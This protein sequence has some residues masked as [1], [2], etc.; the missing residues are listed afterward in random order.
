MS[1]ATPP[2]MSVPPVPVPFFRKPVGVPRLVRFESENAE[3][4]ANLRGSA[5]WPP[6]RTWIDDRSVASKHE[7]VSLK[8]TRRCR[9]YV[10]RTGVC[11]RSE[12]SDER[13][14]AREYTFRSVD[15]ILADSLPRVAPWRL[16]ARGAQKPPP[17]SVSPA[18]PKLPTKSV[19]AT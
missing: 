7:P 6:A 11:K 2:R 8:W 3:G 1:A 14:A 12:G 19:S 15:V 10:K 5:S 9:T 17:P 13:R 16:A 18:P 4:S